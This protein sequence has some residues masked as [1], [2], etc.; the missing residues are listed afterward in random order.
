MSMLPPMGEGVAA[1]IEQALRRAE[2][3]RMNPRVDRNTAADT[4]NEIVG[5]ALAAA[6]DAGNHLDWGQQALFSEVVTLAVLAGL[7][8]DHIRNTISHVCPP[9]FY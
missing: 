2:E 6:D 7:D 9:P 4:T 3:T 1:G 8:S 5:E